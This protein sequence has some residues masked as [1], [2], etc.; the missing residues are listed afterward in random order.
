MIA[1]ETFEKNQRAVTALQFTVEEALAE[2]RDLREILVFEQARAHKLSANL[3]KAR[4]QIENALARFDDRPVLYYD[5]RP[6][7][8][9]VFVEEG[10]K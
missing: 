6:G 3:D 9:P 5:P 1:P 8:G 10:T 4:M 2:L 7:K